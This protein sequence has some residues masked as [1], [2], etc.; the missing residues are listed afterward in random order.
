[1]NERRALGILMAAS[2]AARLLY[3]YVFG[4]YEPSSEIPDLDVYQSFAHSLQT[5]GRF[6]L[7]GVL[8]A[9]R[10]PAYPIFLAA[11]YTL[12][13]VSFPVVWVAHALMDAVT[14]FIVFELG[15]RVFSRNVAWTAALF[16]SFYPQFVFYA[17]EP[18]RESMLVMMLALSVWT[19]LRA[20]EKPSWGRFA[21]SGLLWSIVSLTNSVFLPIGGLAAVGAWGVGYRRGKNLMQG[22]AV[23]LAAF[24]G[25][26]ALW[27]IRNVLVFDR[28]IPGITAGGAHIYV[29]LIVPNDVAGTPEEEA[30]VLADPV[31]MAAKDLPE[32]QKDR[33]FYKSAAR[34]VMEHP[35]GYLGVMTGSFI[36]LWRLYPYERDYGTSY[37]KIKIV[38]LLSDGWLIPL[39]FLGVFLA[40]RRF[41]EADIFLITVFA[42]TFTYMVFW[43]VIR[44]RLP[45]MPYVF[46][47]S[48]YALERIIGRFRP[49]LLP[50][51]PSESS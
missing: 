29:S 50:Y 21:L 3:C 44:Y 47:Y 32:D 33:Y 17:G 15:R 4:P 40:R 45:L 42:T 16:A 49:D 43:A 14:V 6:A 28:F 41:I 22:S 13:G 27:P 9:S 11:L 39:F 25:L 51:K 12:F 19:L 46:L 38:S 10:E 26:Y 1:M 8:S 24:I 7:D 2:I 34:W 36:K 23:F 5:T 18:R 37:R 48:A 31:L 35:L 30:F 20:C